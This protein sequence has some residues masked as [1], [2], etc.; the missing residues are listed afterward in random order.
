MD[1]YFVNYQK[2]KM[3]LLLKLIMAGMPIAFLLLWCYLLKVSSFT[4]AVE[5]LLKCVS[6]PI[7]SYK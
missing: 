1:N 4:H 7:Y 6:Q 5:H 3:Q 2:F